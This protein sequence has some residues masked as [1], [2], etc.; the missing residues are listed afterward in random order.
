MEAG[1]PAIKKKKIPAH[2]VH[3]SIQ[4]ESLYGIMAI[5]SILLKD[6][7]QAPAQE[8]DDQIPLG[9]PKL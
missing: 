5:H 1:F 8:N 6:E 4:P 9:N 2:L 7:P 3:S